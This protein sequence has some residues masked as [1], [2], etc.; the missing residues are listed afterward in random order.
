MRRIDLRRQDKEITDPALIDAIIR[1]ALV[2]RIAL[3][4]GEMPYIVPLSFGYDGRSIYLH[5]A[6]EGRKIDI[7]KR[8]PRVCFEFE[9]DCAV[10]PAQ[11]ACAFTMRYRSV[12]GYGTVSFPESAAAKR[13]ALQIIM[14]QYA[15]ED[16][17]ITDEEADR[18]LIIRIDIEQLSAKQSGFKQEF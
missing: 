14:H 13:E 1:N 4:D 8:N 18:I 2:C 6:G 11:K 7:L 3:I 15:R 16:F 12:I 9:T 5:S 17:A 10:L